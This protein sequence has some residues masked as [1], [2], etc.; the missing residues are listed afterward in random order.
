MPTLWRPVTLFSL[1]ALLSAFNCTRAEAFKATLSVTATGPVPPA[2]FGQKGGVIYL[3][4]QYQIDTPIKIFATGYRAGREVRGGY[5]NPSPLYSSG[6]GEAFCWFGENSGAVI[7]EIRIGAHAF[8]LIPL[9]TISIPFQANWNG[10]EPARARTRPAPWESGRRCP[11]HRLAAKNPASRPI[12]DYRPDPG[13]GGEVD[14][15]CQA[16]V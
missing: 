5:N 9:A 8:G 2:T 7:E 16:P 1:I 14:R 10:T 4:I 11:R 3:R 15:L 12:R 13:G 6:S